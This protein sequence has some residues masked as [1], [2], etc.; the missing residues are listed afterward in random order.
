MTGTPKHSGKNRILYGLLG[1][2]FKKGRGPFH[3]TN[4]NLVALYFRSFPYRIALRNRPL[5]I[6]QEALFLIHQAID[7]IAV[8]EGAY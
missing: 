3:A 4:G 6:F 2:C 7:S 1:L 8:L 5:R